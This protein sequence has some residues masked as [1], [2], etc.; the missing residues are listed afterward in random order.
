MFSKYNRET[1]TNYV[2]IIPQDPILFSGTIR[3]NLDPFG[4]LDDTELQA[5]LEGSGLA[6]TKPGLD[7]GIG[8]LATSGTTTPVEGVVVGSTKKIDLDTPVT[9]GGNNLSQGQRQLLAFARALVRRSKLLILDEATSSTDMKTDDMIQKTIRMSFPDSS[10]VCIA[11]RL[12]TVINFDR[13][14]VLDNLGQG[15]EVVE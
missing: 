14:L 1:V 6:G 11:H 4:E 13:I 9:A 15:G 2:Q 12:S 3:T 8:S 5:A 10:L 7:S